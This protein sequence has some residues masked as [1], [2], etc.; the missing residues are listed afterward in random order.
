MIA[1]T[2]KGCYRYFVIVYCEKGDG[3]CRQ[4]LPVVARA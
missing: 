1:I 4:L 3:G 2:I